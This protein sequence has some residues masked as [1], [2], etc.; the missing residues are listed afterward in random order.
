MTEKFAGPDPISGEMGQVPIL[1]TVS[2]DFTCRKDK[3]A[4]D[5]QGRLYSGLSD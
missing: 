5:G 1:R 2:F 4:F 3:K